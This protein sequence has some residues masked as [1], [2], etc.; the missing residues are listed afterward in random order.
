MAVNKS[1]KPPNSDTPYSFLS[2]DLRVE[3]V[4]ITLPV[5]EKER[6]FVFPR[7]SRPIIRR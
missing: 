2:L 1:R 4:V 7:Q 6:Y 3:P 5:I